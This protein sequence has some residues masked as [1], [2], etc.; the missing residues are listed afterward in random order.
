MKITLNSGEIINNC[1]F[2][3]LQGDT[4][5]ISLLN[6][7]NREKIILTEDIQ[8]IITTDESSI[9]KYDFTKLPPPQKVEILNDIFSP[10]NSKNSIKQKTILTAYADKQF[11]LILIIVGVI[12]I[13]VLAISIFLKFKKKPEIKEKIPGAKEMVET[14]L[15]WAQ[16][17]R[18]KRRKY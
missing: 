14:M 10:V 18:D 5:Y 4:V 13:F 12:S 9:T 2:E 8:S 6:E 16:W 1:T 7:E 17:H 15:F 11:Q 3:K